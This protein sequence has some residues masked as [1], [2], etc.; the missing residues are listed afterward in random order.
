LWTRLIDGVR[1]MTCQ[2][3]ERGVRIDPKMLRKLSDVIAAERGA[4]LVGRHR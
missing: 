2:Q 4:E 3:L 1:K